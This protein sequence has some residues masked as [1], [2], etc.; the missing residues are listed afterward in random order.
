MSAANEIQAGLDLGS[1][2]AKLVLAFPPGSAARI[3]ASW[4]ELQPLGL[5][6]GQELLGLQQPLCGAP[7]ALARELFIRLLED[8]FSGRPVRIQLTGIH[9]RHLA[10]NLQL[11]LINEFKAIANGAVACDPNVRTILEIGGDASRYLQVH[12]DS[13]TGYLALLDYARNG[14]CAAGTGSFIDQ[15][16]ARMGFDVSEV[17]ALVATAEKPANIAGRCSVFAKSD[18]VHAQQRGYSPAA[19]LK[20]L[21]EAVVR[22]Y[23]GTVLRG[24][25]L[26]TPVIFLGGVAANPGVVRA[27]REAL[28]IEI[29]VPGLHAFAAA[30]G[31]AR[32]DGGVIL[33]REHLGVLSRLQEQRP[34]GESRSGRLTLQNVYRV[35]EKQQSAPGN[36]GRIEAYLGI[37]VG[38]VS[39]NL[40]LLDRGG[41]VLDVV[42]TR[43]E[44]KPVQVVRRELQRWR[45]KWA[46]RVE[47]MGVGT[48]GSG[49][50]ITAELVGADTVNDEITAHKTGAAFIATELGMA[51][52]D[53]IFEIGGQ[54]SKF[55]SLESGVVVDFAMNEACAAGTGSFLEEQAGKLGISIVDEFA[56]LALQ[57]SRSAAM[58]ERCTVF[59]EKDVSALLQQGMAKEEIAAG[60]AFSVVQN[61][62]NRVVR[63]RKIGEVIF[64]Q[65]GTAYN[66]A[67]AAA[68]AATLD[69]TIIVPPHC[70]VMGAIGAALLAR[71]RMAG[72]SSASRFHGFDPDAI[73]FSV[74][75]FTCKACSNQCDMQEVAVDGEKSYWGDK[76]SERYRKRVRTARKAV[77]PD[78]FECHRDLLL[79]GVPGPDGRGVKIGIPRAMYFFD[80]FPFWRAY[81]AA[82]GAEVVLSDPT[83]RQTV[84]LGR[85][86][87]IAEPCFPILAAHGHVADLMARGV[88]YIFLPN[89]I[90]AETPYPATYSWYCP[91]GQTLPLVIRNTLHNS[92]WAERILSPVLHFREGAPQLALELEEMARRL[93]ADAASNRRAVAT[94]FAVQADYIQ[95]IK[96]AGI[97]ALRVLSV[98][99]REAV[100]L[101]GRPYNVM[102]AGLN[103]NVAGRLRDTYGIDVIPMDFLSFETID[104]SPVHDNMFWNYG[105]RI[106]QA[107]VWAGLQGH[108]HAIYITNFKCGP[109]SYIKHWIHTALGAP[110]LTLQF[111]EHGNDAGMMTR[112]EAYLQSKGFLHA[113]VPM[114][115]VVEELI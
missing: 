102:D 55:I 6:A 5:C 37:D 38:S 81:F 36:E 83:N 75:H 93:G 13:E 23:K 40:A 46:S 26:L 19:I 33:T 79:R 87:C 1:V 89:A 8:G 45:E 18:M 10:E 88:D 97:E 60:L 66:Q 53:T 73:Q 47:V 49:R 112:C 25:T 101:L 62:L 51:P 16:V 84:A 61:Y 15:Q 68:F 44:G 2:S 94:A 111:D 64:F 42:Y 114:R 109:D 82:L 70:G 43:T 58:G 110:Y 4:P 105:R 27:L 11:P 7:L 108:L 31:C 41:R 28:G 3:L 78:L 107:A 103:L 32:F 34:A 85:E 77:I 96:A 80:R 76:C 98:A 106:L 20:G 56:D 14:E 86:Y 57:A 69:K 52:V 113:G 90:N 39:T 71:D 63:G 50:E 9:A 95:N 100:L 22:N 92:P 115:A 30:L 104:I 91:W 21:C 35:G 72:S 48:T 59:M 17:G 65:G 54:D 12:F 67:V 74:R 29:S 24:K 99:Q